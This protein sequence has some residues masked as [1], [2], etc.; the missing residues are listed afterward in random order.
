MALLVKA[1]DRVAVHYE[2][3]NAAEE[4]AV[5]GH[6]VGIGSVLLGGFSTVRLRHAHR[7]QHVSC[8]FRVLLAYQRR[9]RFDPHIPVLSL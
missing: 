8:G 9:G 7:E 6:A 2:L 3:L 1:G 5:E 4:I